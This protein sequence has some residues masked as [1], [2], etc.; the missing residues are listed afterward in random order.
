MSYR[1]VY[2]HYYVFRYIWSNP[3]TCHSPVSVSIVRLECR[4]SPSSLR[5]PDS[6]LPSAMGLAR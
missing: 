1:H 4:T 6:T 2:R 5:A 3:I